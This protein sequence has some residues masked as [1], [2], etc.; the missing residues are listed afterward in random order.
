MSKEYENINTDTD[1]DSRKPILNIRSNNNNS[2]NMNVYSSDKVDDSS[3]LNNPSNNMN[4][5]SDSTDRMCRICLDAENQHDLIA[6]CYCKGDSEWVHR[7]CLD[8]WRAT[9]TE[10]RAFKICSVCQFEYVVEPVQEDINEDARRLRRYRLYVARD[11]FG[12]IIAVQAIIICFLFLLQV[13]DSKN[14]FLLHMFPSG[15]SEFGAYYVSGLML[16]LACIGFFGLIA[17]CCGWLKQDD[18]Y[19]RAHGDCCANC[20][21]YGCYFFQAPD[22]NCNCND[23][24]DGAPI[25]LVVAVVVVVIFAII[26]L[27]I[28]VILCSILITKVSRKHMDKLW[29]RQETQKYIVRDFA[30]R[31]NELP[32]PPVKPIVENVNNDNDHRV[33]INDDEGL[34]EERAQQK[35]I[36]LS[37]GT[38]LVQP[39]APPTYLANDNNNVASPHRYMRQLDD[40][41][42]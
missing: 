13:M 10:G 6:P 23:S 8:S 3:L 33:G 5:S 40:D 19:H 34:L 16:F 42:F 29:L 38:E 17:Y 18:D 20:N 12:V 21:C 2:H 36:A 28:G 31:R 30:G 39:S 25:L 1:N 4:N 26:G 27:F 32:A 22:C 14:K 35:N 24:G 9:N 37:S 11:I 41:R 7:K 15:I